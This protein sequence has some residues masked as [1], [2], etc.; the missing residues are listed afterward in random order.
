MQ[1][2]RIVMEDHLPVGKD[3]RSG[4]GRVWI[5]DKEIGQVTN[6]EFEAGIHQTNKL[7]ITLLAPAIDITASESEVFIEASP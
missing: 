4:N 6:I 3:G 2:I 7:T 1:K 5:D